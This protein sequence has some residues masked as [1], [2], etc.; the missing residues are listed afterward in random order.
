MAQTLKACVV[1]EGKGQVLRSI[2][3]AKYLL[4][5]QHFMDIMG[6]LFSEVLN[7]NSVCYLQAQQRIKEGLRKKCNAGR[8][9]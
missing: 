8:T 5:N 2:N 6:F 3:I 4:L 1:T 7:D 9:V